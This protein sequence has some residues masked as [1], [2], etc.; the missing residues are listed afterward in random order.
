MVCHP[1]ECLNNSRQTKAI[2]ALLSHKIEVFIHKNISR[3]YVS[4]APR[5]RYLTVKKKKRS[6]KTKIACG[7]KIIGIF[8]QHYGSRRSGDMR[9]CL[10][11]SRQTKAIEALLSHKIEV[12]IHKNISRDYVSFAPRKRY[13]SIKKKTSP[14]RRKLRAEQKLSEYLL[15]TTDPVGQGIWGMRF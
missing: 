15:S 1:K 8:A 9:E 5:K 4:F 14:S 13:F 10:N 11:N 2:E 12:F 6:V 3:D 7:T